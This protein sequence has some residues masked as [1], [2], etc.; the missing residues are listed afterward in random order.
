MKKMLSAFLLSLLATNAEA[1]LG[2]TREQTEARFGLPK[3]EKTAKDV[4]PLIEGARELIFHYEGF[5]IRCALLLASDGVEYIVREEYSRIGA[6]K[7]ITEIELEAILAAEGNGQD[8]LKPKSGGRMPKL[9]RFIGGFGGSLWLRSDGAMA[10]HGS[11]GAKVRLE[12]PHAAR[13][14]AQFDL[15]KE[16]EARAAVPKF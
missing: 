8:W 3:S 14:E 4:Q 9:S 1:R 16:Q 12:L 13:W 11:A 5:Q 15:V 6:R 2:E 10:A 7:P